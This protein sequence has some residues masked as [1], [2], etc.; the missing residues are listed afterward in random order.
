LASIT[1]GP[2][3]AVVAAVADRHGAD[4]A[5][6][7]DEPPAW[8]GGR[9]ESWMQAQLTQIAEAE[10]R[11]VVEAYAKWWLLRRYRVRTDRAGVRSESYGREHRS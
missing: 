2:G 9:L 10:D 8:A 7:V 6:G 3:V 5:E 11:K 4:L 1:D